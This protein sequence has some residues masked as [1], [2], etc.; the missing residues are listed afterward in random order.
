MLSN[1]FLQSLQGVRTTAEH[2]VDQQVPGLKPSATLNFGADDA[3]D[4]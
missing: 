4:T 3:L 2:Q 1:T